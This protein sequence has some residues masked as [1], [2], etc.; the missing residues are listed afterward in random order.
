MSF[1]SAAHAMTRRQKQEV[2]DDLLAE[3]G[4]SNWLVM[5]PNRPESDDSYILCNSVSGRKA[6]VAIPNEW[7]ED[8]RRYN[9]IGELLALA[10]DNSWPIASPTSI[11]PLPHLLPSSDLRQP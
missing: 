5:E 4:Y 9:V 6:E 2:I 8:P 1:S 11:E 10:I 3:S 7:F